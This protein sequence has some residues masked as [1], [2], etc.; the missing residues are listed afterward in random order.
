MKN[1]VLTTLDSVPFYHKDYLLKLNYVATSHLLLNPFKARSEMAL[2]LGPKIEKFVPLPTP[3]VRLHGAAL[4]AGGR[5]LAKLTELV[6]SPHNYIAV[7][8]L[9]RVEFGD[10][11][12]GVGVSVFDEVYIEGQ[13]TPGAI[14]EEGAVIQNKRLRNRVQLCPTEPWGISFQFPEPVDW[15]TRWFYYISENVV[16]FVVEKL[17]SSLARQ[18]AASAALAEA[19][20][21]ELPGPS[22]VSNA[23]V[24]DAS[25]TESSGVSSA[26]IVDV[27]AASP[28]DDSSL[29]DPQVLAMV[30]AWILP[31]SDHDHVVLSCVPLHTAT[32]IASTLSRDPVINWSGIAD[33]MNIGKIEFIWEKIID[34]ILKS[35]I[36]NNIWSV[37][38]RICLAAVVYY[39]WQERNLRL[40][41]DIKRDPVTL[42]NEIRETVRLKRMNIRVKDSAAVRRV[43]DKW[44]IKFVLGKTA[45]HYK[46]LLVMAWISCGSLPLFLALAVGQL[47]D[48]MFVVLCGWTRLVVD[49]SVNRSFTPCLVM[50]LIRASVLR[51]GCL[52]HRESVCQRKCSRVRRFLHG[53][54]GVILYD[55]GADIPMDLSDDYDLEEGEI[56]S[57]KATPELL[58]EIEIMG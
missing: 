19:T 16:E 33:R 30:D 4:D 29:N 26:S 47:G 15:D 58:E 50:P 55:S 36:G 41:Q 43:S 1:I 3:R 40:F 42:S 11:E 49:L 46:V 18:A 52:W 25:Q 54:L 32:F 24:V 5:P 56:P 9:P 44:D 39:I 57:E 2:D 31:S 28:S 34:R 23:T 14:F 27:E 51:T 12:V 17:S 6:A 22:S 10:C 21:S 20:L 38:K 8:E 13:I 35:K 7:I 45:T 48:A 37:I 53:C